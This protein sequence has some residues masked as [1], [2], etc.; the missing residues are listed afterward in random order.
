LIKKNKRSVKLSIVSELIKLTQNG[1]L[2]WKKVKAPAEDCVE[3]YSIIAGKRVMVRNINKKYAWNLFIG[4]GKPFASSR[5][6]NGALVSDPVVDLFTLAQGTCK[7]PNPEV[8]TQRE[9]LKAIR[10]DDEQ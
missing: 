8:T 9:F 5:E 2:K 3:F 1:D 4:T 7:S 6:L 10:G